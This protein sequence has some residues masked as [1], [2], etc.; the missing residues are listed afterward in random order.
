MLERPSAEGRLAAG[1]KNP[2]ISCKFEAVKTNPSQIQIFQIYPPQP[3]KE[4]SKISS[5]QTFQSVLT[6]SK[7]QRKRPVTNIP[8]HRIQ[9]HFVRD[10]VFDI[11]VQ[12]SHR[13]GSGLFFLAANGQN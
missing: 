1:E 6:D 13:K 2:P 3:A 9:K 8:L 5:D 11:A 4:T 12:G 10:P 7:F